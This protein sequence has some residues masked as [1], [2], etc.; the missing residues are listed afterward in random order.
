MTKTTTMTTALAIFFATTAG[1]AIAK[2]DKP[3]G[4]DNKPGAMPPGQMK[5]E[6]GG[7]PPGAAMQMPKPAPEWEAFAKGMEGNWKCDS[8]MPAGAMGPG[9]PEMKMQTTVKI[10]K[11]L[12]GFWLGGN[13]DMKKTKTSPAMNGRFTIG[14]PDGKTLVS[15][16]IDSVGNTAYTTGALGADGGTTVGDGIMMGAKVKIR[17]TTQ[18]KSDKEMFHKVEVDSGK[19]FMS[20]GEDTCKR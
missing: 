14:S 6:G 11:E 4:M 1:A 20:M 16:M 9:S 17:E 12:G 5:K 7:M 2:E 8:V 3:H 18:K 13:F 15:S 19:G 10:K